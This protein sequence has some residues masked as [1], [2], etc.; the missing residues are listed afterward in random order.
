MKKL[1]HKLDILKENLQAHDWTYMYSDSH[2]V[3]KRGVAEKNHIQDL[4]KEL[5]TLGYGKDANKMF[6]EYRDKYL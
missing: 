6:C 2:S 4:I 3:W 5:E 1:K